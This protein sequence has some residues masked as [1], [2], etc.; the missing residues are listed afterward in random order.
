MTYLQKSGAV[1]S[2]PAQVWRIQADLQ[3]QVGS[4][5]V[6]FRSEV[7]PKNIY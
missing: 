1:A 2:T 5:T 6:E 7:N 3:V 4:E